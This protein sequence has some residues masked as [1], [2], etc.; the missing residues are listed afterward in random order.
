MLSVELTD[1][2]VGK[3]FVPKNIYSPTEIVFQFSTRAVQ[4]KQWSRVMLD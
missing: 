1:F 3:L 2:N 4:H